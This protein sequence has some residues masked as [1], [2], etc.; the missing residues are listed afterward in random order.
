[1]RADG[2]AKQVKFYAQDSGRVFLHPGSV[3]FDVSRYGCPWVVCTDKAET[4]SLQAG[5]G[6]PKVVAR[7]VSMASPYAMLLFGGELDV[8]HER[9]LVRV[10]GWAEYAAPARVAVLVRRLRGGLGRALLRKSEDPAF[11]VATAACS[12]AALRLVVGDG[13]V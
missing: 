4:Q 13:K 9:G 11:D 5:G 3:C 1:M 10:G 7:A 2:D 12:R 8:V 6:S